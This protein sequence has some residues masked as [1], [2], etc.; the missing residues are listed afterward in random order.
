VIDE[1]SFCALQIFHK[2]RHPSVYKSHQGGSKEGLS[3]FGIANRTRSKLGS[4]LLRLW[5]FR[6]LKNMEALKERQS[7]VAF[8][9]QQNNDELMKTLGDCLKSIKNL[10]RIL[11]R[12]N[13]SQATMADWQALYRTVYNAVYI[14]EVCRTLSQTISIFKKVSDSFSEDLQK[15][16]SL[17]NRIIDFEES[18][19]ANRFVVKSGV[20]PDLDEKKRTYNGLPDF[21][22]EI[23]R[24]ELANLSEDIQECNVIYLPQ[25]G[26]LLAIPKGDSMEEEDDFEIEGLQFVFFS[27]NTVYYK[28]QRTRELDALLGDTQCDIIDHETAIM[29]R[30]QEVI[31]ERAPLLMSVMEHTA[32]LD[33]LLALAVFANEH[34]LVRP[35]LTE[36]RVVSIK[37]GRHPLQELC[38]TAFVPNDTHIESNR[39]R[40][41]IL[42]GPNASGK[43]VY[44]KQVGLIVFLAH[45][46]SFVPAESAVVG[47]VDAIFTRIHTR[48]TVSLPMSTF[49]ID[50]NQVSNAVRNCTERSLVIMDEFGKGTAT[51]D[52]LS[53]LTATLRHWV[54]KEEACPFVLVSTHFH[55]LMHQTLLPD[56]SLIHYQTMEVLEEGHELVFLYHLRDGQS[57]S[58]QACHI[59]ASVGLPKDIVERGAEVSDMIRRNQHVG[60][61]DRETME[62]QLK[63]SLAMT[64]RFLK[65]DLDKDD[66]QAFLRDFILP[67]AEGMT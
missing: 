19:S 41:K 36:E 39:G 7:A 64:D 50:L 23:A 25:L 30:L 2:E 26:Y 51:D 6:P 62:T 63:R 55:S 59:A 57:D 3:V 13:T 18:A 16:A 42:T 9:T 34:N 29:H 35:E 66:I 61:R 33:C 31:L 11:T 21:M 47:M 40:V 24:Q 28:S 43:S 15:I 53:L 44:L 67:L 5:F 12:M 46:G 49:M 38:V 10:P 65:L 60:R 48:E 45:I 17:I 56:S 58:S 37:A 4:Q 32:E 22:T 54:R 8:F 52:G 14:G 27:N 1:N 20:D